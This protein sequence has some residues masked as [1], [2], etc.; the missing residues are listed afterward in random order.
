MNL[1]TKN[2]KE[3]AREFNTGVNQLSSWLENITYLRNIIA[4]YMRLYNFRIQKTPDFCRNNHKAKINSYLVCDII[5]IMK[6]LIQDV[7]EW[8]N[9]ILHNINELFIEYE[10]FIEI[11]CLGFPENWLDLLTKEPL[12]ESKAIT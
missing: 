4:H 11:R 6:I 1:P 10:D 3:I 8:D 9:Y 7:D 12:M 5:Y 2:K